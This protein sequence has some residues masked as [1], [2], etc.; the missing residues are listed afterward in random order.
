MIH[1]G[2]AL[3]KWVKQQG[4]ANLT[5]YVL[6]K[7]GEKNNDFNRDYSKLL[8]LSKKPFFSESN[9]ES[10]NKVIPELS[11]DDFERP[12]PDSSVHDAE[13]DSDKAIIKLLE[14]NLRLQ[15]EFRKT[16]AEKLDRI[17]R[18]IDNRDAE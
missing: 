11:E 18:K 7:T 8:R 4:F 14:K 16:T 2:D 9:W 3:I 5:D 12:T 13:P 17:E 10:L 6:D 15:A 1:N